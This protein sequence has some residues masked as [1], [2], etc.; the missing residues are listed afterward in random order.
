MIDLK[1]VRAGRAL[2]TVS[3]PKGER[4][5]F[6]VAL[7][8]ANEK[9]PKAS[10]FVGLLTGPNNEDDYTYMGVLTDDATLRL[11][12]ASKYPV[13]SAPVRVFSWVLRVITGAAALP[14]G[15]N[16]QHEGKCCRCGRTLTVP[17]SIESEIGS[18]CAS[19]MGLAS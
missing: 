3:N 13:D 12:K 19:K 18:E 14:P 17:E 11:T 7:G 5:T 6:R 4:Y 9:Y 15:Y 1:W 16:I 2:F 8:K 10:F